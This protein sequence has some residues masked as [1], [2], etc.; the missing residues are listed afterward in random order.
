MNS[1]ILQIAVKLMFPL[2][3][4]ASLLSLFRGH[5]E[6]GGGFI[7]GLVAASAF[8]LSTFT[9][10]VRETRKR[11]WIKP[12][13]LFAAGLWLAFFSALLP[14]FFGF[15]LMEAM[16]ADFYLPFIGRPGTPLLFDIGVYMVVIGIACKIIY[17]IGD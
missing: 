16:W 15:G 8:I 3:L 2:L 7:G 4:L 11:M 5:H 14:M 1:L 9:I 10:G 6:P 17:S 12:I 13:P